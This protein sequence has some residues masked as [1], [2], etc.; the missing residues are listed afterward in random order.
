MIPINTN[1]PPISRRYRK[2]F[3]RTHSGHDES[4]TQQTKNVKKPLPHRGS[5]PAI[6]NPQTRAGSKARKMGMVGLATSILSYYNLAELLAKRSPSIRNG[7][8]RA[9]LGRV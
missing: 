5:V 3:L 7:D 8:P 9:C 6:R 1:S 4:K 2:F